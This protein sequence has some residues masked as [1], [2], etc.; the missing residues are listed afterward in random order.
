MKR[1]NKHKKRAS[2]SHDIDAPYEER[3]LKQAEPKKLPRYS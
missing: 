1:K 2:V 3:M